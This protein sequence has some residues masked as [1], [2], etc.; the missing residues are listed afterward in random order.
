MQINQFLSSLH[1]SAEKISFQDTM[2]VID[3]NYHYTPTAFKNGNTENQAGS[4]EG[5]CKVFSFAKLHNLSQSETLNCFGE[6][7]R[8][9]VLKHPNGSDHANIRNFINSG[10]EGIIFEREALTRK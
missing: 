2:S 1:K 3:A 7:Y 5:S 6:Y 10:W 4:N 9:D 8:N